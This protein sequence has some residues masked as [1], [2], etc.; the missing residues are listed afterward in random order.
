MVAAVAVQACREVERSQQ[1]R[2]PGKEIEKRAKLGQEQTFNNLEERWIGRSVGRFPD[3]IAQ[4]TGDR[5]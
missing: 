1:F 5:P 3:Q 4:E 2:Q